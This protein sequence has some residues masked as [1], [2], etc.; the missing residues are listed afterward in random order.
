MPIYEYTC[1]NCGKSF[2]ALVMSAESRKGIKCPSCGSARIEKDLSVFSPSIGSAQ[3]A[4][5]RCEMAGGCSTPNIPGCRS[6]M[7]GLN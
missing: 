4:M 6:G 3:P 7:C 5:P 2:E 1:S